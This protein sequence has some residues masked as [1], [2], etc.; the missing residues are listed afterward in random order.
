MTEAENDL[1]A[2]DLLCKTY[3]TSDEYAWAHALLVKLGLPAEAPN[4]L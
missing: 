1:I 2:L 4:G 3:F